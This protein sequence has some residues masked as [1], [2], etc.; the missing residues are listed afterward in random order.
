MLTACVSEVLGA[1]Q[2]EECSRLLKPCEEDRYVGRKEVDVKKKIAFQIQNAFF[3]L[4]DTMQ[5][6]K[7]KHCVVPQCLFIYL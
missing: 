1:K 2:L 5:G 6:M 3:F 4:T 7:P